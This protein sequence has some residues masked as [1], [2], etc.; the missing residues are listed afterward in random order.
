V[1]IEPEQRPSAQRAG[2][3]IGVAAA[4]GF[5]EEI[6]RGHKFLLPAAESV[7][8]AFIQDCSKDIVKVS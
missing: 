1:V 8:P 3:I 5:Y 2:A 6:R 4:H 7:K